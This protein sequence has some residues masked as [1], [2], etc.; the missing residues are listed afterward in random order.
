MKDMDKIL[1]IKE[2]FNIT[3]RG[4][5]NIIMNQ[6]KSLCKT[7]FQSKRKNNGLTGNKEFILQFKNAIKALWRK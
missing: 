6:I 3:G 4:I 1:R 2:R 7:Y 5:T